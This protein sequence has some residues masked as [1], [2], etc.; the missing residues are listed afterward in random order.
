MKAGWRKPYHALAVLALCLLVI[1][2]SGIAGY[3]YIAAERRSVVADARDRLAAI[4]DMKVRQLSAWRAERLA[5]ARALHSNPF[6]IPGVVESLTSGRNRGAIETWLG[7]LMGEYD[8]S[9]A[10]L[11]DR[12]F[13]RRAWLPA[14]EPAHDVERDLVIEAMHA[15]TSLL[16][17]LHRD[18]P[19]S[20]A[21]MALV[22]PLLSTS[23]PAPI[24]AL[25]LEI[26][27]ERFLYPLIQAWPTPSR[28]AETL[29][30]RREGADVV[31]LNEL[32]HRKNRPLSLRF[33]LDRPGLAAARAIL[34]FEGLMEGVDYRGTA[35][36]AATRHVPDSPWYLVAKVDS[37][38][39]LAPL[40]ARTRFI[41]TTFGLLAV[42]L[43]AGI[44]GLW[45]RQETRAHLQQHEA[46]LERRAIL[47]HFGYL[48]RY[49]NDII[50]LM[51]ATGRIIEANDRAVDAY[52]YSGD[53]LRQRNVADLR[54]PED[55]GALAGT[56]AMVKERG[57]E[58]L[59]FKADHLRKDGSQF[60]VEISARVIEL[61]GREFRQQI[62]RDITERKRAEA[63]LRASEERF[64]IAAETAND[65]VYEWDLK[66]NV[67]WLGK[68]DEMLGYEPGEFP[69]TLDG[70]AASLYP[71]D[72]ARTMA[73]VQAH[74]EGRAPYAS[75]YRVRRK[76]GVYRWW[77]ARGAAA[78]TPDGRPIRMVGSI[79]DITERKRAEDALRESDA[80]FRTLANAI[81]QLCWMANADGWIFWYN[82]R[83][84]EYTGTKPEQMEGWGWQSVHDPEVLPEVLERWQGSI[85]SGEVFDMIFPLRGGD[86]VFRPFLTRAVPVRDRDG[87][88]ARWFGTNTDISEQ[89]KIEQQI[90]Q[91]N[92]ELEQ[93]VRDRT[94]QLE[95]ANRE[96]ESFSYSVSHDLRGPLR[97]IDGWSLALLEDYRDKLD[98]QAREYLNYIRSDAQRMGQL[99][100]DMLKLAQ[101]SRGPMERAPVDLG[102]VSQA[103]AARL[104]ER[105][106]NRRV[107]FTVQPGLTAWGDAG[108]LE[109]A[110][111]NL[112]DNAWKFSSTRPVA[113]IEFGR[114]E[115][116]GRSAFFVRDNGVG[117]DMAY[118]HKLF[119]AFQRLHKASDFP[120]TGIGLAIV[121]RVVHRHN[122]RVWAEAEPGGGATFYFTLQ[123]TL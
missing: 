66:Q 11:W 37:E 109:I 95:L 58:G 77:V 62:I 67:Q 91:L 26:D 118:A 17:D 75:E 9:A 43:L 2:G 117:F 4:A 35:V 46:E 38:E 81:P 121:Q 15:R 5:D 47:G 79:T 53:E 82:E 19:T 63:A 45:S 55:A 89:R 32:R 99:I 50:L 86:G 116:E 1:G 65:V 18:E 90:Q 120:G 101:V 114:T 60:P 88:V 68:I 10:G 80:Q 73:A 113:R 98:E 76:D 49:A 31:Y 106:P 21:H 27:P 70:W 115:V 41:A 48:S 108:L 20:T 13:R 28:T 12:D 84:Y 102:A 71:E 78:R 22:V 54:A 72:A 29:L 25:L 96:L 30:V 24:G 111:T 7:Q 59:L 61:E 122:G 123:E 85:A 3:L 57:P 93:R 64:R 52:G 92:A 97:G 87:K 6:V 74:L 23:S 112:I 51:D 16:V 100:D 56:W 44:M 105:H 103:I 110:L 40:H 34:G 42:A 83:W 33:P 39:V 14:S 119:G 8:Y 69:R 94:A 36:L 107:E 104:Q